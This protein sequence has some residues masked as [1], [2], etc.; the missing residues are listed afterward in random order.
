M[1]K[2]ATIIDGKGLAEEHR[3]R[4]AQQVREIEA[5]GRRV[6]LDA[7]L[8]VGKDPAARLY[9]ESQ[10]RTCARVGIGYELHEVR[11][12]ASAHEVLG[13]ID[14]L[15]ASADVSAIMV[16]LPLPEGVDQIEVQSRIAPHKDVEG[17]N[18]TNIGNIIYGRSSLAPCTAL[19]SVALVDSTGVDLR[20]KRAVVIGASDHVGKP[21]AVLLMRRDATTVSCN[22]WTW[23]L[24]DL[25][26]TADVLVCAVGKQNLVTA[27]M[28]KPG[29]VVIDVGIN[30]VSD[31][32]GGTRTVG[33]V[34]E[35]V[36][37]VAGFLSPVPGGVGPMTV[38]MLLQNVVDVAAGSKANSREDK[39]GEQSQLPGPV[40]TPG[41]VALN[42]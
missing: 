24:A 13:V 42:P 39:D 40:D 29:A 20:G 1:G 4:I 26:R 32:Q 31:G 27:D 21:I 18:P 34:A 28:V 35:R 36:A 3:A 30:R 22:E 11:S 38:A 15:N 23:G 12:D 19:A 2:P 16:H 6:R 25:A 41:G 33:D 9:A 17:V 7:V 5:S 10:A 14:R 8:T 37:S